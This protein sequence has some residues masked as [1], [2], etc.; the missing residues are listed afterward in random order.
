MKD[1]R[2]AI[3]TLLLGDPTVS[4][5]VGGVRVHYGRLPQ[6]QTAASVVFN[7]VT[8]GLTYNQR[9]DDDLFES[10]MQFD[11]WSQSTDE[12]SLLI[13]AVHDRISGQKGVMLPGSVVIQGAFMA[14]GRDDYD[15]VAKMYR[16]S[17]DYIIW[18][19][20]NA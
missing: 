19:K 18:F 1:V 9:S 6:G 10:R 4:S 7:K 5:M 13:N 12:A 2:P 16:A 15:D 8:E 3:R 20:G 17:R 11:A 14:N